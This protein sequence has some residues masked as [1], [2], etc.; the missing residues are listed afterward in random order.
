M[1]L[2]RIGQGGPVAKGIVDKASL[3]TVGGAISGKSNRAVCRARWQRAQN[4]TLPAPALPEFCP[5]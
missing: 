3:T 4:G 5:Y 2:T 1:F